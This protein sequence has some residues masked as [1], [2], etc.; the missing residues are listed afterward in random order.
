MYDYF[1]LKTKLQDLILPEQSAN[2][3]YA[4]G[5]FPHFIFFISLLPRLHLFFSCSNWLVLHFSLTSSH[6]SDSQSFTAYEVRLYNRYQML[7]MALIMKTGGYFKR[8]PVCCVV[9]SLCTPCPDMT[10][11]RVVCSSLNMS[12]QQRRKLPLTWP[13]NGKIRGPFPYQCVPLLSSTQQMLTLNFICRH[14]VLLFQI[15]SY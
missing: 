4:S 14:L 15:P 13:S 12:L 6:P 5:I 10:P 7:I 9:I 1:I 11:A 2:L 8:F 3:I